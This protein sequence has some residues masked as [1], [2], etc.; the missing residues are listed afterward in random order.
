MQKK[1]LV[2]AKENGGVIQTTFFPAQYSTRDMKSKV[3]ILV[4]VSP[5]GVGFYSHT[6]DRRVR[7]YFDHIQTL[8]SLFLSCVR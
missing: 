7:V 3:K 5:D 1:Y 6:K 2:L 4:G 8:I